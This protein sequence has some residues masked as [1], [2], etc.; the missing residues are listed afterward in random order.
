MRQPGVNHSRKSMV[1]RGERGMPSAALSSKPGPRPCPATQEQW[2][3]TRV[4]RSFERGKRARRREGASGH[5]Y[6]SSRK[7]WSSSRLNLRAPRGPRRYAPIRPLLFQRLS[8]FEW[9]CRNIEASLMVRR[10]LVGLSF[11][12][13]T[14][15]TFG[16]SGKSRIAQQRGRGEERI[17]LRA[18]RLFNRHFC[19]GPPRVTT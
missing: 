13:V 6:F 8:V 15:L 14:F 17:I 9:T 5:R 18:D 2:P 7:A 19:E 16:N 12:F 1:A 11:A 3:A 4:P 10:G